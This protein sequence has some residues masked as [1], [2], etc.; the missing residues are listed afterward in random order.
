[1]Q[2]RL[3]LLT[4]VADENGIESEVYVDRSS[5]RVYVSHTAGYHKVSSIDVYGQIRHHDNDEFNATLKGSENG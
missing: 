2:E 5:G 4:T 1:M 3:E